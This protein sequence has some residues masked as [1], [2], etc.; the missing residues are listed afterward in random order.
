VPPQQKQAPAFR[1]KGYRD[2]QRMKRRRQAFFGLAAIAVLAVLGAGVVFALFSGDDDAPPASVPSG[3]PTPWST[4]G[5][6][7]GPSP[8]LEPP[9]SRFVPALQDFPSDY[10]IY[11]PDTYALSPL[12]FAGTAGI[13]KTADEGE[14]AA[15]RWGYIDGFTAAYQPRGLLAEVIRGRYFSTVSVYLFD[16]ESGAR[17]CYAA[18]VDFYTAF[19]GSESVPGVKG[20]ANESSAWRY[21]LG[22]VGAS[23]VP[24]VYHRFLFRR[25]NMVAVVQTYG[26]D[27]VMTIDR[28]RE[29]AVVVDDRALG[30]RPAPT[31]TPARSGTPA[32]PSP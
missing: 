18:F 3:S 9:A 12:G 7:G 10:E 23:D 32:L 8:R 26:A 31:P 25:G 2:Q 15:E 13:F 6:E 5:T 11:P 22:N 28:A 14:D 4:G 19:A 20:L 30:N 29:V 21:Q 27:A 16:N 1:P 24:A 17:D